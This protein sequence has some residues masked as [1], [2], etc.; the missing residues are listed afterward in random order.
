[1]RRVRGKIEWSNIV[2]RENLSDSIENIRNIEC[3]KG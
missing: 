3:S 2:F 1:M